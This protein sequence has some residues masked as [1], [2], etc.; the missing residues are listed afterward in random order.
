M[1]SNNR[2]T[3]EKLIGKEVERSGRGLISSVIP[4]LQEGLSG[5]AI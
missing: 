1:T 4:N 2:V 3:S 5:T